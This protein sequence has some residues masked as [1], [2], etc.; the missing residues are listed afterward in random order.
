M[1]D[2]YLK[3]VKEISREIHTTTA[4]GDLSDVGNSIGIVIAKYFDKDIGDKED[5]LAGLNHGISITDGT[6]R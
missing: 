5:F 6:H 1:E 4:Y 2:N 3:L